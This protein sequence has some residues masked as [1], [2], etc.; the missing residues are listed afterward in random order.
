MYSK[1][2]IPEAIQN[3]KGQKPILI[4]CLAKLVSVPSQVLLRE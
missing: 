1:V 3:R 2:V 4:G